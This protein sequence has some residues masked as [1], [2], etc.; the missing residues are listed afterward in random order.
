MIQEIITDLEIEVACMLDSFE[1]VRP[2]DLERLQDKLAR[3]N[4]EYIL[5]ITRP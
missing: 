5:S 4:D 1:E 2:R 3:L